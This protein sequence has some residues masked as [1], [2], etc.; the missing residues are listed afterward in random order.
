MRQSPAWVRAIVPAFAIL[1]GLVGQIQAAAVPPELASFRENRAAYALEL[2]KPIA[3]CVAR[4]DTS[5]PVFHGCIDWHSAVHGVWALTAYTWAT[6]DQQYRPLIESLL[7]RSALAEEKE[8]LDRSPRFEMPYGR[9]WFLRLAIDY[10]NAFGAGPIDEFADDVADSLMHFYKK[11]TPDPTSGAYDSATWALINLYDYGVSRKRGDLVDFVREMVR[12][13]YISRAA[14]P[15]QRAEIAPRE[16]MAICT[17]WAWL[18]GKVLEKDEF[19]AWLSTFLPDDL[20]IQPV[21]RPASVHQFGLNFSRAWGLWNLYWKTSEPRFLHL[22][23]QHFRATYGELGDWK[24]NYEDTGHWVAQFGM[25]AAMVT[26]Y[27]WR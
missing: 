26:Y 8:H 27:D 7:Q 4:R 20:A 5:N 23:V 15:L 12:A 16:F 22:Y 13:H 24:R 1:F 25:L 18:V 11:I 17:N 3:I 2:S 6:G 21:Y 9:A 14:C 19:S 10:R